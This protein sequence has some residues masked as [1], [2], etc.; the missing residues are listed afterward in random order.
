MF[1]F[2]FENYITRYDKST[3]GTRIY[4]CGEI[5]YAL[6]LDFKVSR[7]KVMICND[8]RFANDEIQ[9]EYVY[10]LSESPLVSLE[11]Q[12]TRVPAEFLLSFDGQGGSA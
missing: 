10:A 6:I 5:T 3:F 4:H 8:V 12:N 1:P 9:Q 7:P 11:W 2:G